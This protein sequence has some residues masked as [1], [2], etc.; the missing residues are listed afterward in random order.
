[1]IKKLLVASLSLVICGCAVAYAADSEPTTYTGKFIQK[2]TQ[3]LVDTE[4]QLQKEQQAREE[5]R[6]QRKEEL[7][8]KIEAN[9]K[10]RE[11]AAN[12]RKQKFEQKKQLWNQLISE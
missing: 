3:K 2:H 8:K 4:K 5:A 6:A 1:M 7:Q 9:Q 10:A 12:A 11:D